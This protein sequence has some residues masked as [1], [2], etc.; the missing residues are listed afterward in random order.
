MIEIYWFS[1]TIVLLIWASMEDIKTR[2][3]PDKI[4]LIFILLSLPTYIYWFNQSASENE[5]I[6]SI[7][8]I[9]LSLLLGFIFLFFG[10]GAGD[11][12]ALVVLSFT[13]PITSNNFE[14]PIFTFELIP[15]IFAIL[16]FFQIYL[17]LF[18]ILLFCRNLIEIRKFGSLFAFT[19]GSKLG[20]LMVLFSSRRIAKTEFDTISHSDPAEILNLD[21]WALS[22]PL[23]QTL[24]EDDIAIERERLARVKAIE[25]A[26]ETNREYLW[27][28]PQPPGLVFI[29]LAYITWILFASPLSVF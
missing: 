22:A 10:F 14:L 27:F 8:N 26:R 11:S 7:I 2:L 24:E 17:I 19:E 16:I 20:K 3:I 18:S 1:I 21:K 9:L 13:T 29:T 23:F 4:W 28:R 12:K 6:I 5:R 25:D 15:S